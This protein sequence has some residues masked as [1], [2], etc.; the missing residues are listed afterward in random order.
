MG[1]AQSAVDRERRIIMKYIIY[2]VI[3]IAVLGFL[4]MGQGESK[5]TINLAEVLNRSTVA[6]ERYDKY[7]KE[8]NVEKA[9]DQHLEQLNTFLQKV[10]NAAPLL[11][12][13]LIATRLGTDAKFTGFDDTNQNGAVDADEKQLFT[14]ELDAQNKRLIA[15]DASGTGAER[16]FSG[17]GFIAGALIGSMMSRQRAAGVTPSSF[18]NR[19]V[20]APAAAVRQPTSTRRVRS[21]GFRRR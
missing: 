11:Q 17:M 1:G 6:M 12:D 2:G 21:G 19:K 7:L 14:L 20:A 18:S 8:N 15:T 16:S 10:M 5:P 9:T 13:G 3:G 4:S